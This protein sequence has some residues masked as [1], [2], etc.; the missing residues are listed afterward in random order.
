MEWPTIYIQWSC[1]KALF[2]LPLSLECDSLLSHNTGQRE[3]GHLDILLNITSVYHI[4]D[5]L[6]FGPGEKNAERTL[7][8]IVQHIQSIE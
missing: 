5:I 7:E 3:L 1:P 2:I 8:A 4:D 6:F